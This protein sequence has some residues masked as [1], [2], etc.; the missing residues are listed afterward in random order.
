MSNEGFYTPLT[1]TPLA[2]P[3]STSPELEQ[4]AALHT[5]RA[6][7]AWD[8]LRLMLTLLLGESIVSFALTYPL[9]FVEGPAAILSLTACSLHLCDCG[10]V[11]QKGVRL[12]KA[13]AV[14]S[15][16]L[17]CSFSLAILGASMFILMFERHEHNPEHPHARFFGAGLY[18]ALFSLMATHSLLC[19]LAGSRCY[20]IVCGRERPSAVSLRNVYNSS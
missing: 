13:S 3:R 2:T 6:L 20:R 8:D 18:T 16:L 19:A 10:N 15:A 1:A 7:A 5:N 11:R 9:A 4:P 14:L 12:R 17:W